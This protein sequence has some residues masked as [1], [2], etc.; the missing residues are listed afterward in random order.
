MNVPAFVKLLLLPFG[1]QM[2][3]Q[4]CM[5]KLLNHE[6]KNNLPLI[7]DKCPIDH[8]L[9]LQELYLKRKE[10]PLASSVGIEFY[11]QKLQWFEP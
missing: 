2:R 9:P 6:S 4:L 7:S 8:G 3:T 1:A 5:L 10:N 11:N